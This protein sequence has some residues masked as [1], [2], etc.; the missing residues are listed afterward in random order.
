MNDLSVEWHRLFQSV[1][2]PS[3]IVSSQYF[4]GIHPA[5][6]FLFGRLAVRIRLAELL[7]DSCSSQPYIER[8]GGR[9]SAKANEENATK[10]VSWDRDKWSDFE[11]DLKRVATQLHR[12]D[13]KVVLMTDNAEEAE[14]LADSSV[15][16]GRELF[17]PRLNRVLKMTQMQAA[18]A[19]IRTELENHIRKEKATGPP[20]VSADKVAEFM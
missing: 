19:P 6:D 3:F 10:L 11:D 17:L 7:V 9:K 16:E 1:L 14:Q 12:Q 2:T 5:S 13:V 8:K 20:K 18:I 4:W 15:A